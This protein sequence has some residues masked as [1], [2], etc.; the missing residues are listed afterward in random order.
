MNNETRKQTLEN[1]PEGATHYDEECQYWKWA[2]V[3][4]WRWTH[5]AWHRTVKECNEFSAISDLRELQEKDQENEELKSQI[6]FKIK[7]CM[8][9]AQAC[10]RWKRMALENQ[11]D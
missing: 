9:L 6:E 5:G 1:A 4:C 8:V 7:E 2:K 3:V 11:N 10:E